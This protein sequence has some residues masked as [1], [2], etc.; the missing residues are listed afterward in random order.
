MKAFG[1]DLNRDSVT[2]QEDVPFRFIPPNGAASFYIDSRN[3]IDALS[4]GR[5]ELWIAYIDCATAF[6]SIN[7]G[8]KHLSMTFVH[9]KGIIVQ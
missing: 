2:F 1:E 9:A 4:A 6:S 5:F 3:Y 7:L 8:Q